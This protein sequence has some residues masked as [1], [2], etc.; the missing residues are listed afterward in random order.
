L[1]AQPERLGRYRLIERL[2]QGGMATVYRAEDDELHRAVAV[3]LM[4]PFLS[5]SKEAAGRFQREARAV[6]ALRHPN[7]LQVHD[8]APE[9][10]ERPAYLVTELIKGPTL[11]QFL[12]EHGAP[13]AEVAAMIGVKL[14]RALSAA[15]AQG[16]VHRDV[17]PENVMVDQG[18]R[19]VLCDFGIARL[20]ADNTMTATGAVIGSP[21]YMSPEQAAGDELDH[22]SDLFSLGTVLYLVST[23]ALPFSA[24]EPL[25]LLAKIHRGEHLPPSAKNPRVPP[26]LERAIEKCLKVSLESRFSSG[27]EVAAALEY[28]LRADGFG[29]IDKE[30][31][32]YFADPPGY[33]AAAGPKI[34]ASS[35]AQAQ[36]AAASGEVSRALASCNRVLA[37]RPDD[38]AA[39]ALIVR[40]GR[41]VR[42][43]RWLAIAAGLLLVGG[44]GAFGYRMWTHRAPPP[45]PPIVEKRPD[46]TP[47]PTVTPPPPTVIEPAPKAPVIA[48]PTKVAHAPRPHAPAAIAPASQPEPPPPTV[49]EPKP[50]PVAPPL[51]GQLKI[52]VKPWCQ[53]YTVDGKAVD[54]VH[55]IPLPP[56][57]HRVRCEYQGQFLDEPI[58]VPAGE[59]VALTHNFNTGKRAPIEMKLTGVDAISIENESPITRGGRGTAPVGEHKN[60]RLYKAGQVVERK[61]LDIP[62]D[63]CRLAD[64]FECQKP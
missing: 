24:K 35:L 15:H 54:A 59:T 14:A 26:Y 33:N 37:W 1:S 51:P 19:I 29:E 58:D 38:E 31:A 34:V 3:K 9:E 22:R 4:H 44:G 48:E 43:G 47:P 52:S 45:P 16:I 18:G 49:A 32:G 2:G 50:V 63:G 41:S 6:A 7:V 20:S 62:P 13:L 53:S 12:D 21:A 11:K 17:K 27:E 30:I 64:P 61:M 57:T 46:P 28:G 56:G 39:K 42:I 55:P 36:A 10:G 25:A 60:V 23:G 5:S 40:L 8:Y